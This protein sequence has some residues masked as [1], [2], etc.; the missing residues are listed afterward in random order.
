MTGGEDE[1][2]RT[3][4]GAAIDRAVE[5]VQC[6]ARWMVRLERQ[7]R[8]RDATQ[9][10]REFAV[11]IGGHGGRRDAARLIRSNKFLHDRIVA[12]RISAAAF[13]ERELLWSERENKKK[14]W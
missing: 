9:N 13:T 6:R 3:L 8:A 1:Q 7:N 12:G 4:A 5:F 10:N 14:N 2:V 11:Q